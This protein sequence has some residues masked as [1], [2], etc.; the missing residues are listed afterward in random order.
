VLISTVLR[1]AI[2]IILLLRQ[3]VMGTV[4]LWLIGS[5]NGLVWTQ[6]DILWPWALIALSLG[7]TCASLA[8]VLQLGEENASSL[9]LNVTMTRLGLFGVAALL[10]ASAVAIVGGLTFL[11]LLAPHLA[12]RVVGVDARRLF[13]FSM[14]VGSAVLLAADTV[15]QVISQPISIPV[16]AALALL[17]APFFLYLVWRR[18]P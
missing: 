13:P 16:G 17:G 4:L 18:R 11:G 5:L 6:L 1:S 3:E 9:G 15:T 14:L 2:A 8:N 7:L 10:T 12:R